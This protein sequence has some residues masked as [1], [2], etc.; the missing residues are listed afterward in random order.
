MADTELRAELLQGGA[1][2]VEADYL[3]ELVVGQDLLGPR[4]GVRPDEVVVDG[5][6]VDPECP[7][8]FSQAGAGFVAFHQ[9]GDVSRVEPA[10]VL[11]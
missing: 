10:L 6:F 5:S 2:L 7:G 9:L 3:G 8:K 4:L 1:G 11:S